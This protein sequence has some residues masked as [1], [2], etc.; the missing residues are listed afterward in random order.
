[1]REASIVIPDPDT[2]GGHAIRR[3]NINLRKNLCDAFG[4][5]TLHK[6]QGAW[7]DETGQIV[8]DDNLVY[9]V[10]MDDTA[11]NKFKLRQL[12]EA[13]GVEAEQEVVYLRLPSGDVELRPAT[14][15]MRQAA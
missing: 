8:Y 1:M 12:A 4:G 7:R 14:L 13:A 10:A 6:A 3:A 5:Y 9:T 11:E 2:M 15:G